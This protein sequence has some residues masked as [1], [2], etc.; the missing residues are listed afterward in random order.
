MKRFAFRF[1]LS[2]ALGALAIFSAGAQEIDILVNEDALFGDLDA[3]VETEA[4]AAVPPVNSSD[5]LS[6]IDEDTLF[7][8]GTIE[9]MKSASAETAVSAFLTSESV[10]IGGSFSGSLGA[11]WSWTD[12]WNGNHDIGKPD[13]Q[14]L[15]AAVSSLL[16]FSARPDEDSKIYGSIKTSWPFS[17]SRSFLTGANFTQ[18]SDPFT[19]EDQNLLTTTTGSISLPTISV[20]ELFSDFA[21]KDSLFFRF[22]KHTVKWGVG[23]FWSPA[24]VVNLQGIDV[25]DPTAQREGPISFRAHYPVPGTQHNLWAYVLVPSVSDASSLKPEDLGVAAKAEFLAGNW[26]LGLGAF[27]QRDKAPKAMLT[28]TGSL[29]QVALF[30]EAVAGWG[31]DKDWV[32]GV[33]LVP[34]YITTE[35]REDR[36]FFSGTAGFFWSKSDWDLSIS[37][38]YLFNGDGYV[39]SEREGLIADARAAEA[40][41]PEGPMKEGFAQLLKGVVLNS[42]QHYAGLSA[43]RTELG[44]K[45]LSLSVLAIAN[46]S[47]LSGF[48]KP[49]LSYR[50]F[51]KMSASM[52]ANFYWA[53]DAL[54][55]DGDNAE[56]VVLAGGPSVT[57]SVNASLGSGRF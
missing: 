19:A 35:K 34:P 55:G 38:Q 1:R 11:E 53:T 22:G 9:T 43:T 39:D 45:D 57:F 40:L 20:F 52:G 44:L 10:K 16:Y 56:Y 24:D 5:G 8:A 18:D 49:S 31:S 36:A 7:G 37:G 3:M 30:G 50:F 12:P 2:A 54:W 47:D 41:L 4:S 14:A 48:V 17:T 51:D 32:S 29:G 15:P 25:N 42:G 27:Y 28:A 6:S 26:E 33:T 21:W 46:L 13:S 23:Y